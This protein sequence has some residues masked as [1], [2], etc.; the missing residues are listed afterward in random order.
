MHTVYD[1]SANL[2]FPLQDTYFIIENE[3]RIFQRIKSL[4]KTGMCQ[5]NRKIPQS[6]PW[7]KICRKSYLI[8]EHSADKNRHGIFNNVFLSFPF[9]IIIRWMKKRY[10]RVCLKNECLSTV[11]SYHKILT[12]YSGIVPSFVIIIRF[13]AIACEI[14]NRSNGSP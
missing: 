4:P 6:C 7:T 2:I 11:S 3:K 12:L 14:I 10:T 13:S 5:V 8:H 9:K 1:V